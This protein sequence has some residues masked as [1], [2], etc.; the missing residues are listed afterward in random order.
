MFKVY[1]GN[2]DPRTTVETLKPYFE[3]FGDAVDEI[4]VALDDEGQPRGFAI[5]LFRDPAKGQL[6]IET[7]TGKKIN[8]KEIQINE[9]VKKGKR[10]KPVERAPRNSPLGPRAFQRPG[11]PRTGGSRPGGAGGRPF[12]R[13][14]GSA[15]GAGPM[16]NRNPRRGF[17][18]A[19]AAGPGGPSR[20]APSDARPPVPPVG[21]GSRPLGSGM[22]SRPAGLSR[23]TAPG[24][25][26]GA[27]SRPLGTGMR[28]PAPG[29]GAAG[30]GSKPL[31]GASR[32]VGTPRPLGAPPSSSTP[33][34]PTDGVAGGADAPPP[35]PKARAIKKPQPPA[36]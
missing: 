7:L 36:E 30:S 29:S 15:G 12:G 13:P 14:G 25:G 4:I 27:T 11:A 5:V 33:R 9:A 26:P 31:G 16:A 21:P 20:G 34:S 6:A 10:T 22:P 23:P 28:P 1:V 35:P 2:L 3:P 17:G 19:G 32:P 24:A 18:S 8:G